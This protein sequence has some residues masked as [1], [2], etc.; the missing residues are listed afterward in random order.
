MCWSKP[1]QTPPAPTTARTPANN[2]AVCNTNS[3]PCKD[4]T[5]Y[6]CLNDGKCCETPPIKEPFCKC[7]AGYMGT[8][9]E[10]REKIYSHSSGIDDAARL[11]AGFAS[12]VGILVFIVFI[13][14]IALQVKY[15]RSRK[16]RRQEDE[17]KKQEMLSSPV[18]RRR[19]DDASVTSLRAHPGY[20][21]RQSV[22]RASYASQ[23][24]CRLPSSSSTPEDLFKLVMNADFEALIEE[25]NQMNRITG[26][27][28]KSSGSN[29]AD[30]ETKDHC[31]I[32]VQIPTVEGDAVQSETAEETVRL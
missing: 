29:F 12:V 20:S 21:W 30:E 24:L 10:R 2:V 17:K 1:T 11:R 27:G 13:G 3:V 28:A 25:G 4:G 23:K 7:K 6:P 15:Y 16:R 22:K 5:S 9:C 14:V 18:A 19:N 32:K 26:M 31:S 8:F